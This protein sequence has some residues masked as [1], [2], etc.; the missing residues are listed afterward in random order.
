MGGV[1]VSPYDT[2]CS[3]Q[4][5]LNSILRIACMITCFQQNMQ[6][7]Q[8]TFEHQQYLPFIT[9]VLNRFS[10]PHWH[11]PAACT[12]LLGTQMPTSLGQPT[13][14]LVSNGIFALWH[15][16]ASGLRSRGVF[17]ESDFDSS[18]RISTPALENRGYYIP[19]NILAPIL[20][21]YF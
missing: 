19:N 2:K 14:Y 15:G 10:S 21:R 11:L 12:S 9:F 5:F 16:L 1:A 8:K 6:L 3:G 7:Q 4:F 13:T 17:R 18:L 20:F